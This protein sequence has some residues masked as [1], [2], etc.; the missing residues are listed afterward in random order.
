M[1]IGTAT[2]ILAV[3]IFIGAYSVEKGL[4]QIIENR[5]DE[6]ERALDELKTELGNLRETLKDMKNNFDNDDE[7]ENE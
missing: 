5:F 3:L 6:Q 7:E 2:L 1:T 4:R